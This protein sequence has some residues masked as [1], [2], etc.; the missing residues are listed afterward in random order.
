MSKNMAAPGLNPKG[1]VKAVARANFRAC[2]A[3][4]VRSGMPPAAV[5]LF[6]PKSKPGVVPFISLCAD[7]MVCGLSVGLSECFSEAIPFSVGTYSQYLADVNAAA[8]LE[9]GDEGWQDP[10]ADGVLL[11]EGV[12]DLT[13]AGDLKAGGVCSIPVGPKGE[14]FMVPKDGLTLYIKFGKEDL[15]DYSMGNAAIC[16][17]VC[18]P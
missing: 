7:A 5:A 17:E 2:D 8:C 1:C 10:F 12:I 6:S 18:N 16:V 9:E 13:G 11:A 15:S 3:C 4:V 14:G